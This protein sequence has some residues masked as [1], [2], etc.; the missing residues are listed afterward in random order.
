MFKWYVHTVNCWSKDTPDYT[1]QQLCFELG[2]PGRGDSISRW[3]S[4]ID[5]QGIR[6]VTFFPAVTLKTAKR[7]SDKQ[8]K[9]LKAAV[10]K[11]E[12]V[13]LSA[14]DSLEIL[15]KF[16]DQL[17]KDLSKAKTDKQ[18]TEAHNKFWTTVLCPSTYADFASGRVKDAAEVKLSIKAPEDARLKKFHRGP[19]PYAFKTI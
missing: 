4:V 3:K 15:R 6:H 5:F 16:S 17:N 8:L 11:P 18:V 12:P 14:S 9:D 7:K 2:H 10:D 1:T 13:Y 19:P